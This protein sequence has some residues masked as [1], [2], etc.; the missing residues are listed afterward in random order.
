MGPPRSNLP[1]EGASCRDGLA[2][3][4]DVLIHGVSISASSSLLQLPD[5]HARSGS[6]KALAVQNSWLAK[7]SRKFLRCW[8]FLP[9]FQYLRGPATILFISRKTCRDSVAKVFRACFYGVSH[10]CRTIRCKMGYRTDVPV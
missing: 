10:N 2:S 6:Q 9:D 8:K 4:E 1:S 3:M 5:L 7:S